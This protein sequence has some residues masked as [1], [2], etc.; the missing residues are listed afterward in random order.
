LP[1]AL[2]DGMIVHRIEAARRRL[3]DGAAASA[4]FRNNGLLTDGG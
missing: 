4:A 1:P 2:R 3:Y